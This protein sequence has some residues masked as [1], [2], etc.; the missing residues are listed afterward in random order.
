MT[1]NED[2]DFRGNTFCEEYLEKQGEKALTIRKI[3]RRV[4]AA[5]EYYVI[6]GGCGLCWAAGSGT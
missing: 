4:A 2:Q 6:Q 3:R 5:I 1:I